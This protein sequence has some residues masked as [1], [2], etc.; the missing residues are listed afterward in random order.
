MHQDKS[1]PVDIY[2]ETLKFSR[3]GNRAVKR[4]QE[5]NRK[6]GIPN[7]YDFNGHLYYELPNGK[8]TTEDPYPL[9]RETDSD[10]EK[11]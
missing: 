8:L 11:C 10:E 2:E 4:A 6:K 9:S 1:D 7:V 5:E 3:I